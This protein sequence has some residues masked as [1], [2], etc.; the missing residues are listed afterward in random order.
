MTYTDNNLCEL[1]GRLEALAPL[2]DP[3][4]DS[5]YEDLDREFAHLRLH[6][7]DGGSDA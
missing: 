2:C 3:E 5:V 7:S 1:A 6:T 4:F